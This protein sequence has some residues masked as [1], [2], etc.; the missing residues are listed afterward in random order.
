MLSRALR[1]RVAARHVDVPLGV[2]VEA[3]GPVGNS[4]TRAKTVCIDWTCPCRA[5]LDRYAADEATRVMVD[6]VGALAARGDGAKELVAAVKHYRTS[7]SLYQQRPKVL[8]VD[9]MPAVPFVLPDGS[10]WLCI[11]GEGRAAWAKG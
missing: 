5:V 4:P 10:T 8:V 3:T 11:V 2:P 9:G 7:C 1:P 6:A